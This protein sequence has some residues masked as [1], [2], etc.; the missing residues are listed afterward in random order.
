VAFVVEALEAI[1]APKTGAICRRAIGA[2]FP[3]GLPT[4]AEDIQ[5]VAH[6]FPPDILD[7]LELLDQEFFL[8]P[9]NLPDL[10]F[11]YV[12]AR[13]EEFGTLPK[14]DDA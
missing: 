2:A 6:D 7:K 11:A 5:S 3:S 14:P 12:S 13:P 10:L 4:T 8:Y 1:G 9:H